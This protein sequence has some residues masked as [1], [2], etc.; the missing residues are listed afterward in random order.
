MAIVPRKN[1]DRVFRG[2]FVPPLP[3]SR[4]PKL[5]ACRYTCIYYL[6]DR[7]LLVY[8]IC[9]VKG[10]GIWLS[11]QPDIPQSDVHVFIHTY[12][13]LRT[14]D[15]RQGCGV[16]GN[17]RGCRWTGF[18]GEDILYIWPPQQ[19]VVLSTTIT[20]TNFSSIYPYLLPT[21]RRLVIY[22]YLLPRT[23]IHAKCLLQI[24]LQSNPHRP[25]QAQRPQYFH[26]VSLYCLRAPIRPPTHSEQKTSRNT[27][28][29]SRDTSRTKNVATTS[30]PRQ[31][32][33][34]Q[35]TLRNSLRASTLSTVSR[36]HGTA[37]PCCRCMSWPS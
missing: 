17:H 24:W 1:S 32:R 19:A 37:W 4:A 11:M 35:S 31:S 12:Q 30:H 14:G 23:H 21:H 20:I 33:R 36:R 22:L 10:H 2:L 26:R 13:T 29:P 27:P 16:C 3:P 15:N 25:A 28:K 5:P 9:H 8:C 18:P 7:F 6:S 34:S